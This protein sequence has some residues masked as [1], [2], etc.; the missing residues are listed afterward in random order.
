MI[1]VAV[2]VRVI[3]SDFL[4][5]E[6][7]WRKLIDTVVRIVQRDGHKVFERCNKLYAL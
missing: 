3:I 5:F 1:L 6:L 2:H 7:C 4:A